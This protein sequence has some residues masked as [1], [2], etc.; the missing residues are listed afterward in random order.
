[1]ADIITTSQNMSKQKLV[2]QVNVSIICCY[3]CLLK[4]KFSFFPSSSSIEQIDGRIETRANYRS[5]ISDL[6]GE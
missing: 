2:N 5:L 4:K 3:C 1:M 6:Y